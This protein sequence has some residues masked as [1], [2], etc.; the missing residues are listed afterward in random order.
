MLFRSPYEP[1]V[2]SGRFS[3]VMQWRS[4]RHVTFDGVTYGQKDLE[5]PKFMT[6][7]RLTSAPLEVAVSGKVPGEARQMLLDSGWHVRN[8]DDVARTLDSYRDYIRSSRGEF[9]VCKNVFVATNCGVF[10]ERPGCY[11]ASG[12]PAVV[13]DTGFSAHLPCGRGLFAVRTVEEAA[14][15]LDEIESDYQAH[16]RAGRDI[17]VEFFSPASVLR[18]MLGEMGIS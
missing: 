7:P 4:N 5:F 10:V 9:G 8:A 12:R 1:H 16:A 11:M 2:G 14:A 6:L 13:Q 15:A 3:T 18:K 17:A